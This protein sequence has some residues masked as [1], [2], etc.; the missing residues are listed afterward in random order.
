MDRDYFSEALTDLQKFLLG[1][2]YSYFRSSFYK[3]KANLKVTYEEFVDNLVEWLSC[4]DYPS[5]F[6]VRSRDAEFNFITCDNGLMWDLDVVEYYYEELL[7][8]LVD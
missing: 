8:S 1:Y 4:S 6:F 7:S 5:E 3:S 2:Q